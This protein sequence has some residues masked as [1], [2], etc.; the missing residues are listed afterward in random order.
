MAIGAK[1]PRRGGGESSGLTAR[2]PWLVESFRA[3]PAFAS[4]IGFGVP[5]RTQIG[6]NSLVLSENGVFE[7][8]RRYILRR[9]AVL[10]N[11]NNNLNLLENIGF[12][13]AGASDPG[14]I[15]GLD[16]ICV[17]FAQ[18]SF[19]KR[20]R[21]LWERCFFVAPQPSFDN[22]PGATEGAS[23][24]RAFRGDGSH[25]VASP[26]LIVRVGL[27]ARCE[28]FLR[29]AGSKGKFHRCLSHWADTEPSQ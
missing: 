25:R 13:G 4:Q 24:C 10:T 19:E 21:S 8:A 1:G 11:I 20:P 14:E 15:T 17:F 3:G 27:I 18:H 16:K 12:A 28:K 22:V 23:P 26:G 2:P 6:R 5:G 9:S 7:I 29:A